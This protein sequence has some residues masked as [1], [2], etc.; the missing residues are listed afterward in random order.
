MTQYS[1]DFDNLAPDGCTQYFFGATN[2]V[3]Q[4]YNFD[5][6][7]HLADQDQSIC[8]RRERSQCRICWSTMATADYGLSGLTNSNGLTAVSSPSRKLSIARENIENVQPSRVKLLSNRC[9]FGY[10]IFLHETKKISFEFR[11]SVWILL[12]E[13]L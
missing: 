8:V 5:G 11:L 9:W 13:F 2:A 6:G 7:N 10:R 12:K 4:T 1:C 3:V